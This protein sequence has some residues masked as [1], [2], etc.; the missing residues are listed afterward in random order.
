M[1]T[2]AGNWRRS[3]HGSIKIFETSIQFDS[4]KSVVTVFFKG[5]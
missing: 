3:Y 5:L 1:S 4:Y 2:K